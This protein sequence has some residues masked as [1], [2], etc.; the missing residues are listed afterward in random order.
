M[1]RLYVLRLFN[2]DY[3]HKLRL[4]FNLGSMLVGS[5]RYAF[6]VTA[7]CA[8]LLLAHRTSSDGF[9]VLRQW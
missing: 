5:V 8:F 1:V 9:R 6:Q 3:L 7:V 4:L 2:Y